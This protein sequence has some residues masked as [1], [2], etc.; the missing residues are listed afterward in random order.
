MIGA[1]LLWELHE[2]WVLSEEW[3]PGVFT[4]QFH[5]PVSHLLPICRLL[6]GYEKV[7][8]FSYGRNSGTCSWMSSKCAL[9]LSG[10][11]T[12][13]GVTGS[14]AATVMLACTWIPP[15]ALFM[16]APDGKCVSFRVSVLTGH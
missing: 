12:W 10:W 1:Y 13:Q 4:H 6:C 3:A 2:I 5:Q 16:P 7:G 8:S 9:K 11:G 15:T 14:T